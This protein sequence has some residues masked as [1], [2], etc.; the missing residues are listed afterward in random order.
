[1]P[2]YEYV[3]PLGHTTEKIGGL[4]ATSAPCL[5][6]E[7][8]YRVEVNHFAMVGPVKEARSDVRNFQEAS[9]EVDYHY[10]K[11]ENEGMPVKRP[12]LWKQAKQKVRI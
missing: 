3:C 6:G 1:M 5:C 12:N 11:A 2:L 9:A 7:R 4:E 8:A 10:T